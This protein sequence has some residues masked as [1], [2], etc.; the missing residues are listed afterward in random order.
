MKRTAPF[1][2]CLI[3]GGIVLFGSAI[4]WLAPHPD[5]ALELP[6]SLSPGHIITGNFSVNPDTLYY[7]DIE[8]DDRS[9]VRAQCE[10]RSVLSTQWVLSSDGKEE[11]GSSPWEDTGLTIAVL[12]SEKTQY[13]FDVEV[14]AGAS[15][16]NAG[17]PRLKV[18]SHPYPSDLYVALTW[19]SIVPFGFGLALLVRPYITRPFGEI[20]RTRIFPDMVLHNVLPIMKHKPLARIQSLPHWGLFWAVLWILIFIFMIFGPLPSKGLFVSWRNRD[21]VVWEKSP[22]P[23]S[24]EVYVGTPARFFINGQEVGR[25]DLHAK[26]MEELERRAEWTVYFEADPDVAYMNAVYAIDTIQTCGAKLIWITPKMRRDWQQ[27]TKNRP[28]RKAERILRSVLD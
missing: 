27:R 3:I 21:A 13:A 19:F 20:E 28:D 24:L 22:W 2:I 9:Q 8:L 17:K 4:R 6:V 26:L 15:C 14:L 5:V 1:G 12:Y 25:N 23:N 7:I 16:L 10:P 18:Q 11:H